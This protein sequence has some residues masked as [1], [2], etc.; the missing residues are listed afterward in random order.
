[1]TNNIEKYEYLKKL[2]K[3]YNKN[4]QS[5]KEYLMSDALSTAERLEYSLILENL[6]GDTDF[7]TIYETIYDVIRVKI[8]YTKQKMNITKEIGLGF[9]Y[10]FDEYSNS[11]IIL[12]FMATKMIEEILNEDDFELE[13]HL[14]FKSAEQIRKIGINKLLI[15]YI[16]NYDKMLSSYLTINIS[17][18]EDAKIELNKILNGWVDYENKKEKIKYNKMI[19]QVENYLS[20]VDTIFTP[21]DVMYYIANKLGIIEKLAKYDNINQL[22]YQS[23]LEN[24]SDDIFAELVNC[25]EEKEHYNAVK[26]IMTEALFE[27]SSITNIDFK[28]KLTKES[29]N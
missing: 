27:K 26:N 13:L 2:L 18:L 25:P 24:I 19:E 15:N 29:L 11:K 5:V 1:M 6:T 12:S 17:L 20:S 16:S 28:R 8:E 9:K 10:I 23:I 4:N 7:Q 14:N 3:D 21:A 22:V